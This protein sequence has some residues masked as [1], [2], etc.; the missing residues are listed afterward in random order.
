[1]GSALHKRTI[2]RAEDRAEVKVLK[3]GLGVMQRTVPSLAS[4][5]AEQLFM[6]AARHTRPAWEHALLAEARRS[7]LRVGSGLVP[8][9]SWGAAGGPAVVLV[10]GWE[11]RGAQLGAFVAP[12]LARGFRVIAFDAPGHGEATARRASVFDHAEALAAALERFE[13]V[14][15]VVAHSFGGFATTVALSHVVPQHARRSLRLVYVASPVDPSGYLSVF[16]RL[17]GVTDEV[18]A[19]MIAR[20]EARFGVPF[21][22]LDG[23][24]MAQRLPNPMLV[25]HDADDSEVP[26]AGS[27]ALAKHWP[28][29]R[30]M[31]THG[32]G[33]R[34]VLKAPAVLEAVADF[35]SEERPVGLVPGSLEAELYEREARW[36]A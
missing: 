8:A 19:E 36:S 9:W 18:R 33:H 11:G 29:A 21:A 28:G 12:L 14:L 25:V 5:V 7:R 26:L 24:K 3:A 32:Y 34:R 1:M 22:E 23:R 17:L 30:S 16:S 6:T 4:R 20:I 27:E 13:P 15:G 2:V 10:H 35:L 31:V